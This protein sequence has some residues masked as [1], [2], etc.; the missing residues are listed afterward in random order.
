ML[1][2]DAEARR[3]L[4]QEHRAELSAD[5]AQIRGPKPDMME[6]RLRPL[7]RWRRVGL[8]H[9]RTLLRPARSQS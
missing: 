6:S 8:L 4:V 2:P 3:T 1:T 5:A 7:S 9:L